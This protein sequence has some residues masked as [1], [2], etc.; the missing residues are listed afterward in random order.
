MQNEILL[1]FK[2]KNEI[3]KFESKCE[4]LEKK[5]SNARGH[6][7]PKDKHSKFFSHMRVLASNC[8]FC[9]FNMKYMWK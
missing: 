5:K 6:Q 9:I 4:E 1:S 2:G 7:S 3:V 8:P